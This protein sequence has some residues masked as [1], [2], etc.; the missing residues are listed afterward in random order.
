MM[1]AAG[2]A[3][4]ARVAERGEN[5][6]LDG[7]VEIGIVADDQRVLPAELE[8]DLRQPRA[9]RLRDVAADRGGPGE[10]DDVHVA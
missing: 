5:R 6:G 7:R 10:A 1:P 3:A 2:G 8:A 9:R 4:L